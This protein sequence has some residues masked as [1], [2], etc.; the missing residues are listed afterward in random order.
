MGGSGTPGSILQNLSGY[1][2][3]HIPIVSWR[4]FGFP[5]LPSS[6]KNP[7]CIFVSFSGN[8]RETLSG[9]LQM[10]A[11][12]KVAVVAAGGKLLEEAKKRGLAFATFDP[13]AL[14][15]R[16][17]YGKTFY[18]VLSVLKV[19]FPGVPM[20]DLS[21]VI[22]PEAHEAQGK[23]IA[24]QLLKSVPFLYTSGPLS[25]IGQIFKISLNE[26][27]KLPASANVWPEMNHNELSI[28]ETKP[29]GMLPV[30]I[31]T[32]AERARLNKEIGIIAKILEEYGVPLEMI[33]IP[34]SD[35]VEITM[36]AIVI[37]E[38]VG[39]YTATLRGLNP[40][41]IRTVNRIKELAAQ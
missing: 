34:G 22:R 2:N 37:A 28:F 35:D 8:T 5:S 25:H 9:F 18:G 24:E 36:N 38:W 6:I 32:S 33:E 16:Q 10:P 4:D 15:P 40:L 11:G 12:T 20:R 26:S 19:I 13:S 29:A 27:G 31:T 1:A 14:Q 39:Y 7:L 30:F 23:A 21:K 17:G 3:I 41:S